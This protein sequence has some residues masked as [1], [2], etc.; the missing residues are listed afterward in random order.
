LQLVN[1]P[2]ERYNAKVM[3]PDLPATIGE[4]LKLIVP[5][6]IA[7]AAFVASLF[8]FFLPRVEEILIQREKGAIQEMVKLPLQLCSSFADRAKAGELS[9]KEARRRAAELIGDMRYGRAGKDYFWILDTRTVLVM[10]PYRG[11]LEGTDVSNYRDKEGTAVF[12]EMVELAEGEGAGYVSY[13]WQVRDEAGK[14]GEKLSYISYFEEWNWIIGTGLYLSEV[15]EKISSITRSMLRVSLAVTLAISLLLLSIIRQ[16]VV[17][18]NKRSAAAAELSKSKLQ[19]QQLIQLMHEGFAIV[20][21]EGRFVFVNE[22]FCTM[23]GYGETEI[24][25]KSIDDFLQEEYRRIFSEEM[26]KRRLGLES[27]YRLEWKTKGGRRLVTIVSP[28]LYH[29]AAGVPTGSFAVFT[30][31]TDIKAAEEKLTSLLQEKTVLLKE[32]HHRVKN[33]LQLISSLFN[34]QYHDIDKENTVGILQD[35]QMRIQTISRVHEFLYQS[36]N[37]KDIDIQDFLKQ[38]I[39]DIS[40]AFAN[41]LQ[42]EIRFVSEVEPLIFPI[43]KAIPCGLIMNELVTNA[44]KHAFSQE[45]ST[46]REK[47][48]ILFLKREKECICFGVEDNGRGLTGE[49]FGRPPQSLGMELVTILTT[50]L[51]GELFFLDAGSKTGSRVEIRI[52]V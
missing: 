38:L 48:V 11:D 17:L 25:H 20:D 14:L 4:R 49:F 39:I 19:Y 15:E 44:V 18:Q 13:N 43:H 24:L 6:L 10:H 32:I 27:S 40:S 36:A 52:S 8:L 23:L 12:T 50:Q 45:L 7:I 5:S 26:E 1:P 2:N 30:D 29:D 9:T 31:I 46:E 41:E 42:R 35:S 51:N 37:F 47:H 34:L 21:R 16:A 3:A 33:N 28:R 22:Q